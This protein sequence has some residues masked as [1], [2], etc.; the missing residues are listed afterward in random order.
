MH[1]QPAAWA[2]WEQAWGRRKANAHR[3]QPRRY[4]H[5]TFSKHTETYKFRTVSKLKYLDLG[6]VGGNLFSQF[7]ARQH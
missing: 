7:E 1:G 2:G 4:L 6:G 5:P 3:S